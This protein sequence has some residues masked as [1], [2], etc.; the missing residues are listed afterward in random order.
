[1]M[2]EPWYKVPYPN[3]TNGV[4]YIKRE[5][6]WMKNWKRRRAYADHKIKH[7]KDRPRHDNE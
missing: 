1:M 5:Y 4:I 7:G 3:R 2:Y 6:L